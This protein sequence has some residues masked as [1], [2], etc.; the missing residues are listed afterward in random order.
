MK[1]IHWVQAPFLTGETL[2]AENTV[3]NL[4]DYYFRQQTWFKVELHILFIQQQPE[5]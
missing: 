1:P 3:F 4:T 5:T 2:H